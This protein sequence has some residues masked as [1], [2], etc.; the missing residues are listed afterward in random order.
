M[1]SNINIGGSGNWAFPAPNNSPRAQAK[2]W[3]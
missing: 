3:S 2:S 1:Q